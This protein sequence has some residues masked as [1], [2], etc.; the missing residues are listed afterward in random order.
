MHREIQTDDI[1]KL[2]RLN[3]YLVIKQDRGKVLTGWCLADGYRLQCISFR[4][5]TV[6]FN[7]YFPDFRQRKHTVLQLDII[8]YTNSAVGVMMVLFR[9]EFWIA[10]AFITEEILEGCI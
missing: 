10:F 9:L 8:V 6:L 7:T 4:N 1:D 5:G 2:C 3:I